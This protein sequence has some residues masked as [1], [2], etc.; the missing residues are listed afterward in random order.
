MAINAELKGV[1]Q[2]KELIKEQLERFNSMAD[3]MQQV[4]L[5]KVFL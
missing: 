4:G 1:K 2:E 5:I 3:K